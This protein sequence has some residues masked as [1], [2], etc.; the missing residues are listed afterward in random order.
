[1]LHV[2]TL[3]LFAIKEETIQNPEKKQV[4]NT[5]VKA[6]QENLSRKHHFVRVYEVFWNV[7]EGGAS[8]VMEHL[9][10]GSLQNLLESVGALSEYSIKRIARSLLLSISD[11]HRKFRCSY[12]P[13]PTSQ[14][15][16]N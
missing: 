11:I 14:V 15:L 2:P 3:K 5:W 6:W 9:T 16:F 8:L 13:I 1:M 7:P 12:G 4:L 10:G